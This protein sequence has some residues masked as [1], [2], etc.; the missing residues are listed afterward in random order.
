VHGVE[1]IRE[2]ISGAAVTLCLDIPFLFI[3]LGVMFYYSW[4]LTV[5]VLVILLLIAGISVI[6]TPVLRQRL[7]QQF[8]LGARN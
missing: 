1:T 4:L 2:F 6:T 5:L 8:L 3:F 7:N